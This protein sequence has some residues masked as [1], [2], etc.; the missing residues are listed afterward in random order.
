M[1]G[2]IS[3]SQ[4]E[5]FYEF[6]LEAHVPAHHLVRQIDACLDLD[7]LRS[8]LEDY[9]SHTGRPSVDPELMIRM[10]IVGY[11]F[12]IRSERRLC[13]EVHLN[14]A[15]RWFC[16]LGLDGAVPNHSTFSKNRHGRF[17][18][19]D[20]LRW[21]FDQVVDQCMQAGLVK[22]DGFAV[23][24]SLVPAD[25]SRQ[26]GL[27]GAEP[28]DWGDPDTRS[29]AVREYLE[30]LD[31]SATPEARKSVSVSDPQSQWTAATGGPAFFSYSTNYMIDVE[32]GVILDVEATPSNRIAEVD[33]TKTM[34]ERIEG[35][36]GVGPRKLM[37]DTAYGNARMLAWLVDDK[38]IEPHIPVWEKAKRTDG[39]IPNSEFEWDGDA[40]EYRCPQGHAL[41]PGRRKFAKP[42]SGVTKAGTVLYRSSTYDCKDCPIKQ[43][44]CPHTPTRKIARSIHEHA[45]DAARAIAK[46]NEYRRSCCERKKVEMRFA[47]LKRILGLTRLRLRGLSGAA[48]EFV[49]AATAQN[50]RR[51][52]KLM[53]RPPPDQRIGV[54][55]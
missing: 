15:Y 44:C 22:G 30:A 35:R 14:L 48:D 42:R 38:G 10:L 34:I 3:D 24:A 18:D 28:I 19:N 36:H 47:H 39:A 25:A 45:R 4:S 37:A 13:D 40:N 16:R 52:A 20:T 50:L 5:L 46:T 31:A 26:R 7:G 6:S 11:C 41:I 51:L 29:R 27:A 32:H 2:S 23:D 53:A 1:M 8:H 12:G 33:S 55:G 21:V 9:Y 17:R 54:P 49:L 43:R